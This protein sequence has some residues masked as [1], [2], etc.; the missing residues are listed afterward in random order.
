MATNKQSIGSKGGNKE[1]RRD[2]ER[3]TYLDAGPHIGIVVNNVDNTK[4]GRITVHI[5]VLSTSKTETF[6]VIYASPFM[7]QTPQ[8]GTSSDY[9]GTKQSSGMWVQQ[10]DI[11]SEVLLTF[12]A[13]QIH[14]GV[15]FA[16][17][18]ERFNNHMMP[19]NA[20]SEN[21]DPASDAN[22]E[23]QKITGKYSNTQPVGE[24][25]EPVQHGTEQQYIMPANP[26]T[27][28]KPINPYL[29]RI[30]KE[31]G[32]DD[33]L[34]RGHTTSSAQRETPSNVFGFS[35]KGRPT[36]DI[37]ERPDLVKALR[38]NTITTANRT[39][40]K[41]YVD[42]RSRK[43]GHSFVLDD[44]DMEGNNE[45]VRLRSASGHQ[46]LLNDTKGVVY[47]GNATGSVWLEFSNDGKVDL[48]A[49]DS[50]NFRT[51][52]FNFHADQNINFNAGGNISI[53]A[54]GK[55]QADAVSGLNLK[56]NSGP[57]QLH[58]ILNVEIKSNAGVNIDGTASINI[59]AG[60]DVK[61][62]GSCV[63]LGNGAGGAQTVTALTKLDKA[64]TIKDSKGFWNSLSNDI[65]QT[66][67]TRVPTHEPFVS[68][69]IIQS[70]TEETIAIRQAE[71]EKLATS[72]AAYEKSI[73][74]NQELTTKAGSPGV[75][76]A[77]TKRMD[78]NKRLSN[79][80]AILQS[81]P[82]ETPG[83]LT[84]ENT[85]R[86]LAMIGQ[87]ESSGDYTAENQY[88]YIGKYQM[89]LAALEDA[90]YVRKGTYAEAVQQGY[91]TGKQNNMNTVLNDPN[92]WTGKDGV[93]NKE[94]F[95]TNTASQESAQE[96]L[97]VRNYNTLKKA[98]VITASTPQ[99]EISGKL[100]AAHLKG[101]GGVIAWDRSGQ[102]TADGFGTTIDEY[103]NLGR[104]TS[105][106]PTVT[107]TTSA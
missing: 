48:Y 22:S 105:V 39:D 67:S 17:L 107:A 63:A 101:A 46:V 90:G 30:Y 68:R 59:K 19:G 2:Q 58:A 37:K 33:D 54:G 52:N 20:S 28:K 64:D 81:L 24:F 74:V 98:G 56:T 6:D 99:D 38:E 69:D 15:W 31:Q 91:S 51:K 1:N 100:M 9:D 79:G 104:S 83:N 78:P 103:Y 53:N 41:K 95:L 65:K 76:Q 61:I 77:G 85:K 75:T 29:G 42:V 55:F 45:L 18:G 26:F 94:L 34:I 49:Q 7:S 73:N 43:H 27:E 36:P 57:I 13:G 3:G 97:L 96:T 66:V 25:H 21:W 10:P 50:I 86:L 47:V 82:G 44:G 40:I 4:R 12:P 60:S 16:C 89:G 92:V 93:E 102:S 5:P 8:N 70:G 80:S 106:N 88:G 32:L 72:Q 23:F 87:N 35:T 84:P 14:K 11:G 71:I 62:D